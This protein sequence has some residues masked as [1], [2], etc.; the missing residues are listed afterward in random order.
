MKRS[1][2]HA[3]VFT[4]GGA[5]V[6]VSR[7]LLAALVEAETCREKREEELR[8]GEYK[9]SVLKDAFKTALLVRSCRD[10]RYG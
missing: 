3:K 2:E 8:L 7:G 5:L 9:L 10:E 6:T 4:V 1:S